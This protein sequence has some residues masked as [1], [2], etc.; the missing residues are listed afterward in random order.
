VDLV[1]QGKYDQMVAWQNGQVV[2]VPLPEVIL[3]SPSS[4]DANGY[5]VLTARSLGIYVGDGFQF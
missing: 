5:L 2:A 1:A 4:V 3:Q